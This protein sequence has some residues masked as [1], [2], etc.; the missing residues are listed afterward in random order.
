MI[1]ASVTK[2][3]RHLESDTLLLAVEPVSTNTDRPFDKLRDRRFTDT[4]WFAST[5]SETGVLPMLTGSL[6]QAQGP[7]FYRYRIGKTGAA[8][9]GD[10]E[11][12][13]KK[14]VLASFFIS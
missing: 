10:S 14:A 5:G 4:D 1:W 9:L 13:G 6:L 3:R 2:K 11:A 12:I 8:S 7:A